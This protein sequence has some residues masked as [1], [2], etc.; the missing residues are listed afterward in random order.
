MELV[1]QF[2]FV[3]IFSNV[4]PMAPILSLFCNNI[5]M[6]SQIDNLV[7][8][9]RGK[10]ENANGIGAWLLCLEVITQLSIIMNCAMIYFTSSTY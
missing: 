9:R 7:Y 3:A 1:L 5:Q 6:Q 10:A 4:F 8:V 2:G